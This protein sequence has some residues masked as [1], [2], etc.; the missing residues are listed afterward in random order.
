MA[1]RVILALLLFLFCVSQVSSDLKIDEETKH[2]S[3]AFHVFSRGTDRTLM[4]D[5]LM[6]ITKYIDNPAPVRVP[7]L[8][9]APAPTPGHLLD[10]GGLCKHR[11]SQHSR[12]NL[13]MR[14][15]GTCCVRCKCVPPGTS[16][17]R[18]MC[19]T[20]YTD[21]TTHRNKKKCP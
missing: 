12:Q 16:G 7:A 5:I 14:A 19:G 15:C 20:C 1:T 21:L 17:N 9:L 3:Q 8:V 18:E 4:Q 2:V 11:C 13:C 6:R 10:C